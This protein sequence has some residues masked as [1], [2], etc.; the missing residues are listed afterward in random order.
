MKYPG[1]ESSQLEFKEKMP[2]HDQIAK[3]VI[4][5]CNAVGG[6]III[7][8]KDDG[9]MVGMEEEEAHK[10]MEYLD[11]MIYEVCTPPIIPLIYQQRIDGAVLLVI[12]VSTGVNKPYY[13][14]SQGLADGVYVRL[15]RSTLKANADMIEELKWQS[16]GLSHDELPVYKANIKNLSK[17]RIE[18]FL[19]NRRNEKKARATE[20]I[21]LSYDLLTKEHKQLH[22]HCRR[23]FT[24]L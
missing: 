9:T 22:P 7:G 16:R 10:A 21:M 18:A 17:K 5:L 2:K 20:N 8:V 1:I 23:H 4:G 11:K 3:T 6:S 13:K 12:E 14:S 24:F 15:G 19:A